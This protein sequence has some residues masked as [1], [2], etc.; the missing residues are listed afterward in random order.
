MLALGRY[1]TATRRAAHAA[2]DRRGLAGAII[3][4]L[5][6]VASEPDEHSVSGAIYGELSALVVRFQRA[7][8]EMESAIAAANAQADEAGE[9]KMEIYLAVASAKAESDS[10]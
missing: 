3:H 8:A 10:P 1:V 5:T 6:D 9:A 7:E 4:L 2:S